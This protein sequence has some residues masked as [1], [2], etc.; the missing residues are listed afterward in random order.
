MHNCKPDPKL[1]EMLKM[2]RTYQM[3]DAE[4]RAQRISFVYGQ[5]MDCAPH[6][7]KDQIAAEHDRIYGK[8]QDGEGADQ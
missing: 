1:A 5:L 6:I 2:A 3:T 7:T 4:V 8:P